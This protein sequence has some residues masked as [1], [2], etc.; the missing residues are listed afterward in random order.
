MPIIRESHWHSASSIAGLLY[1]IPLRM[2]PPDSTDY[3]QFH[4][5]V[6]VQP[7]WSTAENTARMLHWNAR[8]FREAG[9]AVPETDSACGIRQPHRILSRSLLNKTTIGGMQ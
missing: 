1:A 4:G 6:E 8:S 3:C 5:H 9:Q 2:S 7:H